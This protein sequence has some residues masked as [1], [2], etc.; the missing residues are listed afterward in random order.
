M[1]S[2]HFTEGEVSISSRLKTCNSLESATRASPRLDHHKN[3]VML[4]I[5]DKWAFANKEASF[6]I[7]SL[8]GHW[9]R[10]DDHQTNILDEIKA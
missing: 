6:L 4:I 7:W 2:V 8:K 9:D 5:L 3:D 1:A 10:D